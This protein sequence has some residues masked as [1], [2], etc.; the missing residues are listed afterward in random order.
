MLYKILKNIISSITVIVAIGYFVYSIIVNANSLYEYMILSLLILIATT[1]IIEGLD[2]KRKWKSIDNDI[3]TRIS[4]ISDCQIYTYNN[5]KEWVQKIIELTKEGSHS[6]DSAALDSA[7]RSKA[8]PHYSSIWNYL[9][10]CSKEKRITFRHILR[11]RN[12]N[13]LNLLYRIH[14]GN[15]KNNSYFAYYEL[16]N[17]FSFPTFGVIDGRYIATRSPYQQ[18]VTPCYMIIDNTKISKFFIDYFE[19]LWNSSNKLEKVS[20]LKDI[21]E[22]FESGYTEEEKKNCLELIK[23]IEK[24]GIVDDI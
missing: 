2:E 18:G 9:N 21:Y 7:T 3:V 16:P 12:N 24:E 13:F 6:F 19:D 15:S 10:M 1:F 22:K 17:S 8:K 14:S 11:V 4:S 23:K 5:T 20:Q